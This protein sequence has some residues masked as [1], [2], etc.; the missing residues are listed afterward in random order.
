MPTDGSASRSMAMRCSA[1]RP[2]TSNSARS[3]RTRCTRLSSC[4]RPS[5][6]CE[7]ACERDAGVARQ[8]AGL[9]EVDDPLLE[10]L[11]DR[12]AVDV[13]LDEAGPASCRWRARCGTRRPRGRRSLAFRRSGRSLRDDGDVVALAREVVGHGEDAV[14]VV[15]GGQRRRQAV[16]ALVVELDPQRAAVVVDRQ[17]LGERAVRRPGAARGGGGLGGRPSRARDGCAC[18]RAPSAPRSAAR[19]RARRSGSSAPGSASR[20][21]VSRT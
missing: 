9:D 12:R 8:V 7:P 16:G 17:R 3:P 14:V 20:T 5:A 13:E 2:R 18:L 4:T 15:V 11:V 10:Q 1:L 6:D 19:R 21:E